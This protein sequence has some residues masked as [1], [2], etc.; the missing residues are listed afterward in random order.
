MMFNDRREAGQ[1]LGEVLLAY[2][3][4][5]PL[6]LGLPRGGVVVAYEVARMLKAPL[7][8]IVARK[9]GAPGQPELGIGAIA[10]GDTLVVDP[11]IVRVLGLS[12]EDI[13]QLAEREQRELERR[14]RL[15]RGDKP[16][17]DVTGRTV[18]VVDDGLATGVTAR[19]A[20]RSL[21]KQ[22]PRKIIL[23]VP[24][25]APDTAEALKKEADEVICLFAPPDFRAVGLW[26]RDFSQTS[27]EEVIELLQKARAW[28][29]G[30]GSP[31][32]T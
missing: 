25:C 26:Y 22:H 14:I 15:Y 11:Y 32:A 24:V 5:Q 19:A 4:E 6:V 1:R 18:I 17:P 12:E 27:D 23:A 28:M 20:M 9:I 7:D 16:M 10:P 29:D 21:R 31:S 8:V 2:R 3:D 30:E 13:R